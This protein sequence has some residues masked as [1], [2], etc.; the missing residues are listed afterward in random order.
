MLTK[1]SLLASL[2][3]S[4]LHVEFV[5]GTPNLPSLFPAQFLEC[6]SGE[7]LNVFRDHGDLYWLYFWFTIFL[8][9]VL[10]TRLWMAALGIGLLMLMWRGEQIA[11][12]AWLP[13]MF[14]AWGYVTI[15]AC[16][17]FVHAKAMGLSV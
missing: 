1:S 15:F 11:E 8:S 2:P 9:S 12:K 3:K 14:S 6:V 4:L 7:L 5:L 13:L 17:L 16:E 10:A